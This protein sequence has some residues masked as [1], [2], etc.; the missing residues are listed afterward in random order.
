MKYIVV[1][2]LSGTLSVV[3][4]GLVT[5]EVPEPSFLYNWLASH[6]PQQALPQYLKL[7]ARHPTLPNAQDS[8]GWSVVSH[9]MSKGS[10]SVA[11]M[12]LKALPEGCSSFGISSS[13]PYNVRTRVRFHTSDED[14]SNVEE[15]RGVLTAMSRRENSAHDS[16]TKVQ[17]SR[18]SVLDAF[19]PFRGGGISSGS[20]DGGIGTASET[21]LRDVL[22]QKSIKS[23][24]QQV[25]RVAVELMTEAREVDQLE[26]IMNNALA[27]AL[28]SKSSECVQVRRWCR[29]RGVW[30]RSRSKA[31]KH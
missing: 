29:S 13:I 7:L 2:S 28:N 15:M 27:L 17:T 12:I 24:S 3:N 1:G 23:F 10:A 19:N 11:A 21:A 26:L 9:A 8:Q 4:V 22:V 14:E 25:R 18:K 5:R 20:N 6:E 30:G 31:A 16:P